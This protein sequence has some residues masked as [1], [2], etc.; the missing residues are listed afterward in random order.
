MTDCDGNTRPRGGG[1]LA[2]G[3]KLRGDT[4]AWGDGVKADRGRDNRFLGDTRRRTGGMIGGG[5]NSARIGLGTGTG[6]LFRISAIQGFWQ[7]LGRNPPK[8]R[9]ALGPIYAPNRIRRTVHARPRVDLTDI[10]EIGARAHLCQNTV[11]ADAMRHPIRSLY[12]PEPRSNA[13]Y[14]GIGGSYSAGMWAGAAFKRR[15]SADMTFNT[16]ANSGFPLPLS[17][18]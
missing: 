7:D 16:V 11:L 10:R 2:G 5:Q 8:D 3:G 1:L 6:C 18:R 15:P 9:G 14:Y 17:A 4:R 13:P 12:P